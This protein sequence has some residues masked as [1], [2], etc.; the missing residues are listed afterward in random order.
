MEKARA[1]VSREGRELDMVAE[2]LNVHNEPGLG[3]EELTSTTHSP[4]YSLL[5]DSQELID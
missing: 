3:D 4:I 2:Q 1:I 5:F